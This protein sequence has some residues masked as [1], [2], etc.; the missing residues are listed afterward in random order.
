MV[1]A[2]TPRPPDAS[3]SATPLLQPSLCPWYMYGLLL[4]MLQEAERV[5]TSLQLKGNLHD[6]CILDFGL[7]RDETLLQQQAFQQGGYRS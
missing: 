7:T 3:W 4:L 2:C 5:C 1:G 6:N